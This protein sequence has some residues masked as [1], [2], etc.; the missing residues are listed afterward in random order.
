METVTACF[1]AN[2]CLSVYIMILLC[3]IKA[4][5]LIGKFYQSKIRAE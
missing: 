4:C 1:I 3:M 5:S 2:G